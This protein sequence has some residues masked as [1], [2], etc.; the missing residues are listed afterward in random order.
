MHNTGLL[1]GT[2]HSEVHSAYKGTGYDDFQTCH[3]IYTAILYKLK[4][5]FFSE[6]H[7][8]TQG[9]VPPKREALSSRLISVQVVF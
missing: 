1:S 9:Q 8:D 3:S 7:Q 6:A 2:R 5:L 4:E